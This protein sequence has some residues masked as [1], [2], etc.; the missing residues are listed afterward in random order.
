MVS[1]RLLLF[2]LRAEEIGPPYWIAMGAGAI[3]V[4]AGAQIVEMRPTP[5]LLA[6]R[7]L[8]SGVVVIM[9]A[10]ATWLI[11][12]LAA[13]GW[14]QHR[15][16]RVLRGYDPSLWSIVFPLGMYAVAGT[17]LG[18]VNRLPLAREMGAAMLW[19]AGT[20]WLITL[21]AMLRHLF[22]LLVVPRS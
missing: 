20:A 15:R 6:T 22:R 5:L 18:Q 7:G 3:G 11:P 1:V 9:W 14:W 12:A 21:V 10:F 16:H 17:Y 2:H 13:F 4:L 8:I 19:V